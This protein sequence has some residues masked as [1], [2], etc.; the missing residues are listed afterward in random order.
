MLLPLLAGCASPEVLLRQAEQD[1]RQGLLLPARAKYERVAKVRAPAFRVLGMVGVAKVSLE[2]DD[3][4]AAHLWL[5]RATAV[6]ETGDVGEL[7]YF[8]VAELHRR[9]GEQS[10]ALNFYYRAAS[11][12]ERRQNRDTYRRAVQAIQ[13]MGLQPR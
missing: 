6:A 9:E 11:L 12:A 2:L 13:A 4:A 3:D 1:Q 10:R 8:E 7:G 5:E